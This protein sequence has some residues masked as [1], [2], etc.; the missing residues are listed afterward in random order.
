MP[1]NVEV[2]VRAE[3]LEGIR[4]RLRES[5]AEDRGLLRQTDTYFGTAPGLRLKLRKQE[6]GGA[7]LI[8]YGRPDVSGIRAST[9]RVTKL[10]GGSDL[11]GT[12]TLALGKIR[13]IRKTRHLFMAGRTRVHLDEVEGLGRFLELEVVLRDGDAEADGEREA[14]SILERL[15][16][17]DAPRIAGS[18]SDL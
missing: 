2:K 13:E 11:A 17:K 4:N 9:Y 12:L 18:Y 15:G 3:D 8:A 6:P 7:E 14:E 5:G 16:L 1:R 10:P